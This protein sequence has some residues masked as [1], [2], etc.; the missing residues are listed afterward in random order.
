MAV[1]N[2]CNFGNRSRCW[3]DCRKESLHITVNGRP[4]SD[5]VLDPGWINYHRTVELTAYDVTSKL[6]EGR[7]VWELMLAM[8]F[9]PETKGTASSG[10][11]VL[12]AE[13]HLFHRDA[14]IPFNIEPQLACQEKC[15]LPRLPTYTLQRLMIG[16]F[17]GT[18]RNLSL[19]QKIFLS[20]SGGPET[21]SPEFSF[22]SA[23]YIQVEGGSMEPGR[24]YPVIHSTVGQHVSSVSRRL[25]SMKVDKNDV[26]ALLNALY[27]TF[28]SSLFS[29]HSDCPHIE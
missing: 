19:V 29:C 10:H 5:H 11:H 12:F 27:W 3:R 2:L 16:V 9:M 6:W 13:L 18:L 23:R 28:S 7:N 26:N 4:A 24:G 8:A 15:Y 22:T 25:G 1:A 17:H 14:S 20:G 21:L